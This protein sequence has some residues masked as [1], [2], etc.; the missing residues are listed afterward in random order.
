TP[1]ISDTPSSQAIKFRKSFID[2]RRQNGTGETKFHQSQLPFSDI[3]NHIQL[4]KHTEQ[5]TCPT[6]I[7]TIGTS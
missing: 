7:Q 4:D 2:A 6:A 3:T 1:S 5:N